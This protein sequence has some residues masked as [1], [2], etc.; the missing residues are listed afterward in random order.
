MIARE[1]GVK[2]M[3]SHREPV[4]TDDATS[5]D[6][7]DAALPQ[8]EPERADASGSDTETSDEDD[9]GE[10]NEQVLPRCPLRLWT[11]DG[12]GFTNDP[13][14]IARFRVG[15]DGGVA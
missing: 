5:S 11:G 8:P 14:R 10:D 9:S 6:D 3:P 12:S 7:E 1:L 4:P 13:L 2:V 15:P